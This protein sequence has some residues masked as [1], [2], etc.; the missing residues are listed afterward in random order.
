MKK[1]NLF[2]MALCILSSFSMLSQYSI[3]GVV[4]DTLRNPVFG[5]LVK[6]ENTYQGVYTNPDGEFK[7]S[8]LPNGEYQISAE[9]SGKEKVINTVVIKD[10]NAT[11][12]FS[13]SVSPQ[14]LDEVS[15]QATRVKGN[16]PV[17]HI[18][19]NKED[20][21]KINLGQDIASL[22]K[23]T[24]SIV[25]TSDAGAG[26][27]YTG[28]RIRGSDATRI[29]ITVNGIPINDA[30]SH[31]TF[32]VNM[33]DFAS[34]TQNIQIQ[35]G[36]GSSTNGAAAFGASVNLQTD[37]V[38]DSAYAEVS[39]SY[40]SFN[41]NK[42]TIRLGTGLIN[43]HWAMDGRLSSISSDG[44][45]DRASADLSSYFLQGGYYG[46]K[47]IVKA[48]T[49]AGKEKTY[50]A[51]WGTPEA[52]LNNDTAGISATIA[53]NA[54]YD[55]NFNSNH[56]D[57]SGRTYNFYLYD[58]EVDNYS[59]DH[60]QLHLTHEFNNKL[61][62][63]A[64]LHYTYGRGYYEQN[65][66]KD[67]LWLYD[68]E[69]VYSQSDTIHTSD[70]IRR[71][72]L[73]N[74]FYG[75][76]YNLRYNGKKA[77]LILGG[78]YNEY[79]G[80]H[81]G[82]IIWAEYSSG[83]KIRDQFYTNRGKKTDFNSY[84]KSEINL[85]KKVNAFIDLQVRSI[86]YSNSGKDFGD[87]IGT[88]Q[89]DVDTSFTFFNPKFGLTYQINDA[90]SSYASFGVAN[91]EPVRNDFID[92]DK[93][94]QP[95]HET[96]FDYEAGA[97]VRLK[98]ILG[99]VNLY[100]MDYTNQLVLTG[101]LSD[102]GSNLRTNVENSYRAGIEFV[103]SVKITNQL[104]W[105]LNTTLSQNKI[106]LYNEDI[107]RYNS[108]WTEDTIQIPHTN[109]DISLSPS[110]IVGSLISYQPTKG[111]ELGLQTKYVGK[112]YLD[113]TQSDDRDLPAYL[114]SDFIA[115][116]STSCLMLKQVQF[117]LLVNN[118]F[119]EMYSSNGYTWG[120]ISG[121]RVS[122]NWLYPQAGTNFLAGVTIKF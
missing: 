84:I 96:L 97:E 48:V 38:S 14:S 47:T 73:D 25:T 116:Y 59:Q 82:E 44:Y 56:L 5:A 109:T 55:N 104:S 119:N 10:A 67:S 9:I 122:E 46:E 62:A 13:L 58:N 80:D 43:K 19:V 66:I 114:V 110:I 21:E 102:V 87:K 18:N 78:G 57:T 23:L 100:Y 41:T 90:L 34:S 28:F 89:I 4:K 92:N 26:V 113:N 52:K 1:S 76:V 42:N 115:S 108:D 88:R 35:R 50:Q 118:I 81:F 29:N 112:Q 65:R 27:G 117:N 60:Y 22:I 16:A 121:G 2:L 63:N 30:E 6:I 11:A 51:W 24:P 103:G 70:F 68:L 64:S 79:I 72:W 8:N 120:F 93:D 86:G 74:H 101:A 53:N 106:A 31:G 39:S 54:P 95:S 99:Q 107:I 83:S 7:L 12:N 15:I 71:R 105:T 36:V 85:A 49:F 33:P 37:V 40:G 45:L 94:N 61:T 32:W 77:N 69:P 3:S 20:Y 75:G 98:N 91:R 17:A 111:L